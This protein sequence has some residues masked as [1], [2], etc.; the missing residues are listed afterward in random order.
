VNTD[1]KTD[2]RVSPARSIKTI[3]IESVNIE[4]ICT[5]V[6]TIFNRVVTLEEPGEYFPINHAFGVVDTV[7]L[8]VYTTC[9]QSAD[10]VPYQSIFGFS[11]KKRYDSQLKIPI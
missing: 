10:P 4:A 5:I 7:P 1:N 2:R 9:R 3:I 6:K 11:P 8:I